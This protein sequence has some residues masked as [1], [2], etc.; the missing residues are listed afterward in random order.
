MLLMALLGWHRCAVRASGASEYER[1]A[2]A[3]DR[4]RSRSSVSLAA[5]ENAGLCMLGKE[6]STAQHA[7]TTAR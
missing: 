4:F 6:N 2:T 5:R 3:P 7:R 1:Y